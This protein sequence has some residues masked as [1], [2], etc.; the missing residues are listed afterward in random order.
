MKLKT[1]TLA[2]F[3]KKGLFSDI[4]PFDFFQKERWENEKCR[5]NSDESTIKTFFL[6]NFF[7]K[8]NGSEIF[9][10]MQKLNLILEIDNERSQK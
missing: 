4:Q 1:F 3:S 2:K 10:K 6:Y 5:K 8:L 9:Q 7:L